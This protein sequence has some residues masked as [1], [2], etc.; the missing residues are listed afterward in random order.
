MPHVKDVTLE[1]LVNA[2][3][4]LAAPK[5]AKDDIHSVM[6]EHKSISDELIK[7][8]DK[9]SDLRNG[10]QQVS[11]EDEQVLEGMKRKKSQLGTKIGRHA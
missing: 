1:E 7:Q 10:G 9:M 11:V 4:N 3:L 6:M 5:D 2:K 8:R